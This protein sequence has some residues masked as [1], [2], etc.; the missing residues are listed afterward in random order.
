MSRSS[1]NDCLYTLNIGLPSSVGTVM[2]MGNLDAESNTL[3]AKIAL[4]HEV[5]PPFHNHYKVNVTILSYVFKKCKGFL[6]KSLKNRK[7]FIVNGKS[8]KSIVIF[9]EI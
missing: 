6:K 4:C 9:Y 3:S 1:V 7:F 2:R 8:G 5:T